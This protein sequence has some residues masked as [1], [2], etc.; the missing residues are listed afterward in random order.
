[1][2]IDYYAL[3]GRSMDLADKRDDVCSGKL[4]MVQRP[5]A[6]SPPAS[7]M[8]YHCS[9]SGSNILSSSVKDPL[10]A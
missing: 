3:N 1:M 4:E 9:L 7:M 5:C 8:A 10:L 2:Y 6:C